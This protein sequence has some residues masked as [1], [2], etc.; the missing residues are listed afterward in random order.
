VWAACVVVPTSSRASRPLL[1]C[2][3]PVHRRGAC[4]SQLS[5][6][7]HHRLAASDCLLATTGQRGRA[8]PRWSHGRAIAR[9]SFSQRSPARICISHRRQ[10]RLSEVV[11]QH[12]TRGA[13]ASLSLP[14][15]GVTTSGQWQH[16]NLKS[17]GAASLTSQ[18]TIHCLIDAYSCSFV[19]TSW[20][21]GSAISPPQ[22]E[23]GSLT[24]PPPPLRSEPKDLLLC[25]VSSS[26]V[27]RVK[28]GLPTPTWRYFICL[29][30]L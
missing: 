29:S 28:F 12:G 3:G 27:R 18:E 25:R 6:F 4:Q 26:G 30:S 14:F 17:A 1:L 23:L 21:F 19:D 2:A 15:H 24:S 5:H 7:A 13:V 9:P 10:D 16:L 11:A 8:L 20:N 22:G